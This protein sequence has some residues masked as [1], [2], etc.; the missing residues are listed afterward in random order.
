MSH[1]KETHFLEDFL[2]SLE[3]LLQKKLQYI[4]IQEYKWNIEMGPLNLL[5]SFAPGYISKKVMVKI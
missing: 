5:P 4:Y 3:D 2:L 1:Y